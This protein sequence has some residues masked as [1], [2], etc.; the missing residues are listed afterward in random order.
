MMN[1][2]FKNSMPCYIYIL[3]ATSLNFKLVVMLNNVCGGNNEYTL[4]RTQFKRN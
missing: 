2:V 3:F 4:Y 1:Q